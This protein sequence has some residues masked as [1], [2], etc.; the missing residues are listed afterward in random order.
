MADDLNVKELAVLRSLIEY[1]VLSMTQLAILHFP[2]RQM[3]RLKVRYFNDAGLVEIIHQDYAGGRGK[4]EG[5]I[6]PTEKSIKILNESRSPGGNEISTLPAVNRRNLNHELTINWVRIHLT[7]TERQLPQLSVIFLHP[8]IEID[9]YRIDIA[10]SKMG[11]LLIPDGIFSISYAPQEKSLLFFLEIDMGTETLSSQSASRNDFKRKILGY[12]HVF[13]NQLYKRFDDIFGCQ[14]NGFRTLVVADSQSRLNQ[15]SRL[16]KS[17]KSPG[18]IWLTDIDSILSNGISGS[19]WLKGGN[20][21]AGP[22]SIIGPT[23]TFKNL[24]EIPK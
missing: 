6:F 12:Q 15:L 3:A 11:N 7:S 21:E 22:F 18:F 4:P 1:G 14:F 10:D 13:Q 5:I 9:A 23:L 8:F 17:M 24:V 20:T 2:S 16:V 19:I